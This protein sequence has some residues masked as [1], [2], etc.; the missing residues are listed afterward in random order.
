MDDDNNICKLSFIIQLSDVDDYEG[1][2]VQFLDEGGGKYYMPRQRGCIG[3]FDSRTQHRVQKVTK[4]RRK[5]LIGFC[6]GPQW[7]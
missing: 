5:S 2:N 4:R 1:G 3:V 6:L 7:T